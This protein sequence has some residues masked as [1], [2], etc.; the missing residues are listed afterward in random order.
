MKTPKPKLELERVRLTDA[1]KTAREKKIIESLQDVTTDPT[2]HEKV[3]RDLPPVIGKIPEKAIGPGPHD[4]LPAQAVPAED[5]WRHRSVKMRCSTCMWFVRK[6][7][8]FPRLGAEVGRC[9]RHAP[10]MSGWPVMYATDWCGDHKLDE[11]KV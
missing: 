9:R 3:G 8:E 6:A 11:N 1:E 5:R 2:L 7:P 4:E 10:T